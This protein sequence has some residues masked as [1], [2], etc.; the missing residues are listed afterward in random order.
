MN[1]LPEEHVFSLEAAY[2]TQLN[3]K[4]LFGKESKSWH[5][6]YNL[7]IFRIGFVRTGTGNPDI[8]GIGYALTAGVELD[9]VRKKRFAIQFAPSVGPG[10]ITK[11]YDLKDNYKNIAIGSN[12]NIFIGLALRAKYAFKQMYLGSEIKFTHFSNGAWATPN[13]GINLPTLNIFAGYSLPGTSAPES[14]QSQTKGDKYY[15]MIVLGSIGGKENYPVNGKRY[16]VYN[17]QYQFRWFYSDKSAIVAGIDAMHNVARIKEMEAVYGSEN[18]LKF[19]QVG[20]NIG[21]AKTFDRFIFFLQNGIYLTNYRGTQGLIYNRI[22]GNMVINGWI[23]QFALK[24]HITKADHFEIG[25]GRRFGVPTQISP[26][27]I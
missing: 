7:P 25:V 27:N 4:G 11:P 10:L 18:A 20:A 2:V 14:N 19:T 1:H 6:R 17:L 21:F 26:K 3:G 9:L 13:L 23:W 16:P 15:N 8:I 22:G 12:F 24:A 5:Y